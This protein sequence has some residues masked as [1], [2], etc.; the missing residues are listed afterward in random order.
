MLDRY[1]NATE[2]VFLQ[3]EPENMGAW[4]FAHGRLHRLFRNRYQLKHVSRGATGSPATGS[5][6]VHEL[7]H[8]ALLAAALAPEPAAS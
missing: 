2:L 7:E 8:G 5:H 4:N 1:S 6:M 3:E